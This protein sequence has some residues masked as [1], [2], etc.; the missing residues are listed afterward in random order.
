MFIPAM[1]IDKKNRR[2]LR[3]PSKRRALIKYE[4]HLTGRTMADVAKAAGVSRNCLYHAFNTPYPR[5]E[6]VLADALDV[7]PQELFPERY[8]SDGLPNRIMGRRKK[9]IPKQTKN[10]TGGA[11]RNVHGRTAA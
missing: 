7:A 10:T 6:K 11:G 2:L 1:R 4:I 8:D 9:S 3:D 5:M